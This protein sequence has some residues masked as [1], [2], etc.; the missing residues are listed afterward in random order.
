MIDQALIEGFETDGA[1]AGRGVLDGKRIQ[2]LRDAM[3]EILEQSYD[4][5]ERMNDE[6]SKKVQTRD[7]IWR[8]FEAFA[9]FLFHSPVGEVKPSL[10]RSGDKRHLSTSEV[11]EIGRG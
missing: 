7:G 6:G 11:D 3:P 8:E 2:S 5:S 9:R 10:V 1:V 4:P